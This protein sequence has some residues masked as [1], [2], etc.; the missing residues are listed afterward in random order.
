M[1]SLNDALIQAVRAIGGSKVVGPMLWPEK[2]ADAAQR[3]LL[4]CLNPDRP[5]RLSPEQV[6][7]VLKRARQVGYHEATAWLMQHLGYADPVPICPKDEEAELTRQ[8]VQAT[9][10]L[11]HMLKRIE[12]LRGAAGQSP[13][14]LVG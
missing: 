11:G 10:S 4:D 9:E 1:E 8:L 13:V 2:M 14:R 6:A 12:E 3:A 7:L 5:N